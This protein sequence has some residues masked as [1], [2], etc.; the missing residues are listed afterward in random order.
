MS[1]LFGF[2]LLVNLPA[3]AG[4]G[5]QRHYVTSGGHGA[6]LA[7][8]LRHPGRARGGAGS[9]LTFRGRARA[10]PVDAVGLL[11]GRRR[12]PGWDGCGFSAPLRPATVTRVLASL[13]LCSPQGCAAGVDAAVRDEEA[14]AQRR[15]SGAEET[16]R[17][18]PG[19]LSRRARWGVAGAAWVPQDALSLGEI[20][21]VCDPPI[22]EEQAWTV[23]YQR[24]GCRPP[25]APPP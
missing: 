3:G 9:A 8:P 20:P 17:R 21:R 25:P 1:T 7:A 2:R 6:G 16:Q 18:S 19:W 4:R 22:N 23:G 15:R 5:R 24:C 12:R 14:A 13:P 10:R 11:S